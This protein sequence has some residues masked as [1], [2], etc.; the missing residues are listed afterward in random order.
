MG[1]ETYYLSKQQVSGIGS[2]FLM[3]ELMEAENGG[4]SLLGAVVQENK[5]DF[6][7]KD[8]PVPM[9]VSEANI[10]IKKLNQWKKS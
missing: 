1:I 2:I 6:F 8:Y 4:E 7:H 9:L 3:N 10:I 5:K